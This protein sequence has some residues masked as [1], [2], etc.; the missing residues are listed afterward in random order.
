MEPMKRGQISIDVLFAIIALAV[1]L[2]V[3][4]NTYNEDLAV[5][6]AGQNT[7]NE[8]K[9]MLLDAYAVIGAVQAYGQSIDYVPPGTRQ[10]SNKVLPPCTITKS[11]TAPNHTLTVQIGTDSASYSG[12]NLSTI[13]F[14][15]SGT[16]VDSFNCGTTV[17]ISR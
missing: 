12:L 17:T 3:L 7:K 16:P 11:G 4:M 8:A 5:R 15:S 13:K 9:A 2:T 1:F 6:V 10:E 14:T